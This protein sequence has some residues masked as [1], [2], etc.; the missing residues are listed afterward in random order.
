MQSKAETVQQYLAELP[1]ERREVVTKVRDVILE[2]LPDGYREVMQYGMISYVVP[3]DEYPDTYNGEALSYVSLASQKNHYAVY[4]S[5][6]YSDNKLEEW[7]TK[8]Y[9][10]TGKRMDI[11]KSCVRFRK[12]EN[13]PLELIGK[14]VAKTSKDEFID[15]Y[16]KSRK[17]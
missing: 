16:E 6:I 11:G 15:L 14:A 3:L 12:L 5:N 13:L 7:F 4:L 1:E 17:K 10:A 9:K 2:N 8:E